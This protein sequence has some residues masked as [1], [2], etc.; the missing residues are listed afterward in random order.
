[1]LGV[2]IK[3]AAM[4]IID[5]ALMLQSGY[6]IVEHALMDL[7]CLKECVYFRSELAEPLR[8]MSVI[9]AQAVSPPMRG[10]LAI[11][12]WISRTEYLTARPN[13]T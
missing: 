1:M 9:V 5:G 13:F 7:G 11:Q 3:F 8:Q 2:F 4:L 12:S 10:R 6:D